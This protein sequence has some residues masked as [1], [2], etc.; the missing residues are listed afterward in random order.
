MAGT[1]VATDYSAWVKAHSDEYATEILKHDTCYPGIV[2]DICASLEKKSGL[3]GWLYN[4]YYTIS[5][6]IHSLLGCVEPSRIVVSAGMIDT[7]TYKK[8]IHSLEMVKEYEK[9]V[10]VKQVVD[11]VI[12]ATFIPDSNSLTSLIE[13]VSLHYDV[14][15]CNRGI[16][17][18][19][20]RI[21]PL[22]GDSKPR[23]NDILE[24]LGVNASTHK[25]SDIFKLAAV[26]VVVQ[27]A[28]AHWLSM[29]YCDVSV[30]VNEV[31]D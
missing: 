22:N 19:Y 25:Y 10:A 28:L 15:K 13:C 31:C 21:M 8:F 2:R 6:D 29:Q 18:P 12:D 3:E 14:V 4:M 9:D 1:V 16:E 11:A 24:M 20:K 26:N 17:Y 7:Y 30:R 23:I 27:E 5:Y